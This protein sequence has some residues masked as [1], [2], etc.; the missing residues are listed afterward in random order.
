MFMQIIYFEEAYTMKMAT[1]KRTSQIH[2]WKNSMD[3]I[4]L[5]N[6]NKKTMISAGSA[7]PALAFNTFLC[8]PP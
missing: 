8:R 6:K 2:I 4:A 5:M 7:S 3:E 1:A